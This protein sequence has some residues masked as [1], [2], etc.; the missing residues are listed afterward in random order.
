MAQLHHLGFPRIGNK[1]QLKFAQESYWQGNSSA[2]ELHSTAYALRQENWLA[3]Q[4]L[5]LDL[6]TVGDFSLYDQVL[7]TSFLLGNIPKRAQ[8]SEQDSS[9][10]CYFR[11]AR[12]RSQKQACCGAVHDH[13][14]QTKAGEMTKWFNTNYHYIVPEFDKNSDFHSNP[15]NLLQG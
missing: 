12:G 13:S 8:H 7:D 5:T 11:V 9:L 3:Q 1:R 14:D 4:G 10:D 15:E 2:E 6:H